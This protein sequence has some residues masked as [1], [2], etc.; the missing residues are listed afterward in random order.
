MNPSQPQFGSNPLPPLK[1]G[2]SRNGVT[3]KPGFS[4]P[5]WKAPGATG[6]SWTIPPSGPFGPDKMVQQPLPINSSKGGA[7]DSKYAR[8]KGKTGAGSTIDIPPS[9]RPKAGQSGPK[10]GGGMRGPLSIGGGGAFGKI[11]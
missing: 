11:R 8:G 4:D 5:N 3:V 6:T 2:E 10:G 1:V 7:G 9:G